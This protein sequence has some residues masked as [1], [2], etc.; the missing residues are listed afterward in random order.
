MVEIPSHVLANTIMAKLY[1]VLT[2]GDETVPRSE[3]N[4]FTWCTPGIPFMESDFDFLSQGLTGIVKKSAVEALNTATAT[5]PPSGGSTTTG[6][7]STQSP[8]SPAELARLRAQDTGQLYLQAENFARL[9]DFVPDLSGILNEQFARLNVMNNEGSLSERY[10]FILLMSQVMENKLDDATI[11]KVKKMRDLLTVKKIKKNLIDDSETEVT[12]PSPLV[13]LYNEKMAAY[14]GAALDYN[15]RRID[16]LSADDSRSVHYWAMNASILRNRVKAAM[17]DWVSNGY[18]IDYEEIGAYISQVMGRDM[19]LL[20]EMYKDDLSKARLTSNVSGS[21]FYYTSLVPGNFTR[22]SGWTKFW[23]N[24]A[25]FDSY[26]HSSYSFNSRSAS[27]GG[28]FGGL[29]GGYGSKSSSS[30]RSDFK[31]T[32]STENFNLEFM[33]TQIPI[34]RPWFKSG[35][36]TSKYWKFKT[37]VST[38]DKG[39]SDGGTK[40]KAPS[41]YLPAYPTSMICVKGLKLEFGKSSALA[42]FME[43][44]QRNS[45]SGGGFLSLGPLFLGGSGCQSSGSGQKTFNSHY[46]RENQGMAVEG[47][48]V[49]GFKCHILPKSP[50][51][52]PSIKEWV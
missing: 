49:I 3:D 23:F 7:A 27:G 15:A 38:K 48:Q 42:E 47:M 9:V 16:A 45:S 33:I 41:G 51:P 5:N 43:E 32:F 20:K 19:T 2:N 14:E 6:D 21:D 22:S 18:K 52:D 37:D 35:F 29:F 13:N 24:A 1:D 30:S 40:D 10:E 46:D 26:S 17:N 11:A 34:V 36:L 28:S 8:L 44:H 31:S 50:D 25:E 12:E 39:L 4:Y